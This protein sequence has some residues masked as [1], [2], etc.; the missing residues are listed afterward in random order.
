MATIVYTSI[1]NVGEF[2]SARWVEGD[3]QSYEASRQ[4][5]EGSGVA[6]V[7]RRDGLGRVAPVSARCGGQWV[8]VNGWHVELAQFFAGQLAEHQFG[9]VLAP[10]IVGAAPACAAQLVGV[11]VGINA[12]R[13][14]VR[15]AIL[16]IQHALRALGVPAGDWTFE[17]IARAVGFELAA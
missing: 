3:Q 4:R 12:D 2:A 6:I 13:E 1:E 10:F 7:G 9:T 17:P 8:D 15:T 14:D 11:D 5:A 16:R